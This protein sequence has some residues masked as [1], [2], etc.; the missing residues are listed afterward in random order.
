LFVTINELKGPKW[1]N[2]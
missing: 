1:C 2:K